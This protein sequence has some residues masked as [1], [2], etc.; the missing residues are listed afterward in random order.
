MADNYKPL[1]PITAEIPLDGEGLYKPG[2]NAVVIVNFTEPLKRRLLAMN[3]AILQEG[4]ANPF[5]PVS[6]KH[7]KEL[8]EIASHVVQSLVLNGQTIEVGTV[9]AMRKIDEDVDGRLLDLIVWEAKARGES[10]VTGKRAT[11]R[12]D[13]EAQPGK[14]K[15]QDKDAHTPSGNVADTDEAN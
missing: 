6:E 1:I 9:D 14:G 11:F 3:D 13:R 2:S 7:T 10:G 4:R 5:A 8:H 15:P 12:H